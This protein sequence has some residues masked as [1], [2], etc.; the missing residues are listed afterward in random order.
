M[1]IRRSKEKSL[2]F[3]GSIENAK[4]KCL[5]AL[6]NGGFKKIENHE[7]LNQIIGKF[8]NFF[9]VGKIEIILSKTDNG[10]NID[11]KYIKNNAI[12]IKFWFF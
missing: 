8:N 5:N 10:I 4:E 2:Q 7:S 12:K 6:N 9:V 1:A 3:D 11:L